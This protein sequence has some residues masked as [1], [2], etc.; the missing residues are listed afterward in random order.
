MRAHKIARVYKNSNKHHLIFLN[1][2][3]FERSMQRLVKYLSA[4]EIFTESK[5]RKQEVGSDEE[6]DFLGM[7]VRF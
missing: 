7:I 5:Q 4:L 1:Q 6:A 3:A 2:V